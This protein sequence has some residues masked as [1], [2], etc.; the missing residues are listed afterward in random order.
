MNDTR[1][2][3]I[4]YFKNRM[5]NVHLRNLHDTNVKIHQNMAIFAYDRISLEIQLSGLYEKELLDGLTQTVFKKIDLDN[6][7]CLDLGANIGNHTLFF[8][9]Y[10][11]SIYS[12]EPHPDIFD[13]LKFNTKN[14]SNINIFNFGAS[15]ID[16]T[17]I[18]ARN[19]KSSMGGS[20]INFSDTDDA[21]GKHKI[22]LKKIDNFINDNVSFIKIDV[23]GHEL[24]AFQGLQSCLKNY[25]PV[26]SLEQHP[27][28]FYNNPDTQMLTSPSIDYLKKQ[29]Y[30]FFY[31]IES[32]MKWKI[33]VKNRVLGRVLHLIEGIL[34][35]L[36]KK[37]VHELRTIGEFNRKM[38]YMLIASKNEL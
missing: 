22:E 1:L 34:F 15:D 5:L 13:L 38:Y 4:S 25:S 2:S 24:K 14:A 26:I 17:A 7:I 35:G 33:Q 31:E 3:L 18:I 36:P 20:S 8:T 6:S 12:F 16:E 28:E 32:S 11:K 29:G 9:K 30:K 27:N 21:Y 23:E 10:F 19:Q 37:K